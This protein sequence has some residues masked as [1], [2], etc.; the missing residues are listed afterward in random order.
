LGQV[1]G[2]FLAYQAAKR[3]RSCHRLKM[4]RWAK[5]VLLPWVEGGS[6]R[7]PERASTMSESGILE[8]WHDNAAEWARMVR[9]GMLSSR[10][11]VTDQAILEAVGQGSGGALL[12]LGCGEGSLGRRLARQGWQVVGT[13]AVLDLVT[14]ARAAGPGEF[15]HASYDQLETVLLDRRFEAV[16]ANFSLLGEESVGVALGSAR[17]LLAPGG[18]LLIQTL[19]PLSVAPYVDGWRTEDWGSMGGHGCAPTPWYFRTLQSWHASLS[20]NSFTLRD[21]LEPRAPGALAP[22]SLLLIADISS[23]D[24]SQMS[25]LVN[26]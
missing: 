13:D 19:H 5:E 14:A 9:D 3:F 6:G 11:M 18:R 4:P 17:R 16:V 23:K 15:F 26:I 21:L 8:A 10:L 25:H 2:G 24:F 7:S 12:D 22:S 20:A 1:A